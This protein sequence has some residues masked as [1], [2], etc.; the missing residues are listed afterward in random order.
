MQRCNNAI[1]G[2][3]IDNAWHVKLALTFERLRKSE[4][5]LFF[6]KTRGLQSSWW[7]YITNARWFM[8]VLSIQCSLRLG[9]QTPCYVVLRV[10]FHFSRRKTKHI[11]EWRFEMSAKCWNA[12]HSKDSFWNEKV[13]SFR[14]F[15]ENFSFGLFLFV[16][17]MSNVNQHK[18]QF[19]Q[20]A[21]NNFCLRCVSVMFID[22]G[23]DRSHFCQRLM[24]VMGGYLVA[25]A[26][27]SNRSGC[28][29]KKVSRTTYVPI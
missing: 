22:F 12:S 9:I 2:R 11:F 5:I 6:N 28:A 25:S 16:T 10:L 19:G 4:R 14:R 20:R 17:R 7:L 26:Q 21:L 27:P 8:T 3:L 18:C 13:K 15:F 24:A 1:N 29:N 23:R